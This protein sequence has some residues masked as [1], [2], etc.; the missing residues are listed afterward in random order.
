MPSA[1]TIT[2][3]Q[4]AAQLVALVGAEHVRVAAGSVHVAPANLDEIAGTMR[5]SSSNRLAVIPV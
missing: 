3:E 4:I 1:C 5:Y 2:Q